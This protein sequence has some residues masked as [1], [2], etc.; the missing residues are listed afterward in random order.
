M[1]ASTLKGL[2]ILMLLVCL[3]L[4]VGCGGEAGSDAGAAAP[5]ASAA[6]APGTGTG[7]ALLSWSPPSANSDGS[8]VQLLGFVI[9]LGAAAHDLRPLQMAGATD[10]S[11]VIGN[12]P[13]GTHY[14]AVTALAIG[15]AESAFSNIET[16][17]VN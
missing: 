6:L 7:T 13:A 10:T 17:T 5:A 9:Y 11:T 3:A 16:K 8:P 15:G 2:A 14:F 12:L 1:K 4:L